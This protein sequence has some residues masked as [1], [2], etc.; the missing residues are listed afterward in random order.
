V[1]WGSQNSQKCSKAPGETNK[2]LKK[3]GHFYAKSVLKKINLYIGITLKQ[4]TVNT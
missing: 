2:K 4:I 1:H 3:N